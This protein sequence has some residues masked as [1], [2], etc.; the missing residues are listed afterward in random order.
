MANLKSA[1]KQIRASERKRQQ[2]QSSLSELKT[3]WQQFVSL[4]ATDAA[5]ARTLAQNLNSKWDRAVSRGVVPSG[6][7]D[8]KK[9]RI[10]ERLKKFAA[11]K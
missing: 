3:L 1:I 4:P 8:R 11:S 6:R 7:A 5:K 9:T 2:N 10:A